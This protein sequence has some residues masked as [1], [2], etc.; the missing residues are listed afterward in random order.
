MRVAKEDASKPHPRDDRKPSTHIHEEC[1]TRTH[2]YESNDK[3]STAHASD[4]RDLFTHVHRQ[5]VKL[6]YTYD[7]IDSRRK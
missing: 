5:Y 6:T 7:G 2:K 3:N 1:V 4:R